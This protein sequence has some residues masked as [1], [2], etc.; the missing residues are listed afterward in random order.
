MAEG[1]FGF[2]RA[3]HGYGVGLLLV[4][5]AAVLGDVHARLLDLLGDAKHPRHFEPEE[6]QEGSAADPHDLRAER[7][8]GDTDQAAAAVESADAAALLATIVE[9]AVVAVG[10]GRE[11]GGGEA[12]PEAARAVDGEGV[13]RIV[14]LEDLEHEVG[15]A[16]VD[17]AAEEADE[18]G[19]PWVDGGAARGDRDKATKDAVADGAHVPGLGAEELV[20]AD[21]GDA[22]GGGGERGG[23]DGA[24]GG[25]G[26]ARGGDA[27]GRAGVESV[28]WGG[29]G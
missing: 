11:E 25:L 3:G 24:R 12:A 19:R 20:E 8:Q 26:V 13:E 29:S 16:E 9:G 6:Q 27:E 21:D 17:K 10:R 5:G 14:H 1:I 2:L 4:G 23:D 28:P 22:T 15:R 7:R 18:H